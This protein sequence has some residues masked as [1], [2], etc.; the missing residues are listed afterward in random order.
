MFWSNARLK[1]GAKKR[2]QKDN[3]WVRNIKNLSWRKTRKIF[4]VTIITSVWLFYY[5]MQIRIM[6]RIIMIH[7]V[8]KSSRNWDSEA[9][10]IIFVISVGMIFHREPFYF[11][12]RSKIRYYG[13]RN[14]SK[15]STFLRVWVFRA[16]VFKTPRGS[17][18]FGSEFS[19]HPEGL[20]FSGLSFRDTQ[21]V[22]V[23][24]VWGLSFRN[25]LRRRLQVKRLFTKKK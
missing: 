23:F 22:W 2:Y 14:R 4:H 16:W 13:W 25:T 21:R 20:S 19:R 17:E 18:F 6:H 15:L 11:F 9:G 3:D 7:P 24:R 10:I 8:S 5:S 12:C 1:L